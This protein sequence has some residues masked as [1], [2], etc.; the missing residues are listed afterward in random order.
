MLF[1]AARLATPPSGGPDE[2]TQAAHEA[3]VPATHELEAAFM[4]AT[5]LGGQYQEETVEVL[6]SYVGAARGLMVSNRTCD[7]KGQLLRSWTAALM[8]VLG[9]PGQ[10]WLYRLRPRWRRYRVQQLAEL[11]RMFAA[12]V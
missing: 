6:A 2:D 9:G 11:Q 8:D 10:P 5:A 4:E 3:V 7:D 1:H 12:G